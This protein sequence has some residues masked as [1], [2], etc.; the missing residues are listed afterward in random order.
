MNRICAKCLIPY[1]PTLIEALERH[2]HLC[3]SEACRNQLLMIGSS[4]FQAIYNPFI[5]ISK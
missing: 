5:V 2:G 4:E 1:L 3:L